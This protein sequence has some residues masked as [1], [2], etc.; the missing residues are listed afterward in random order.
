LADLSTRLVCAKGMY[1][2]SVSVTREGKTIIPFL[3]WDASTSSLLVQ[4]EGS[5]KES[6]VKVTW[7]TNATDISNA[8]VPSRT[9]IPAD[10]RNMDAAYL[11]KNTASAN[12]SL[13]FADGASEIVYKFKLSDFSNPTFTLE[14]LS[15]YLV[16]VSADGVNYTVTNDYSLIDP[17]HPRTGGNNI[18]LTF[19]PGDYGVTN[20]FYVRI[21]NTDPSTG[22][23]GCV[24]TLIIR[25][26]F[27]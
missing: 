19:V 18:F 26:F 14:V 16:D 23:G 17:S 4:F 3:K 27:G 7:S 6:T 11:F 1:P 25:Q 20:E 5:V 15:N 12:D 10:N 22:W 21:R 9:V 2:Q 24:K 8:K 13:R